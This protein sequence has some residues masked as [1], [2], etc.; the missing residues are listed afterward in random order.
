MESI[1]RYNSNKKRVKKVRLQ[2]FDKVVF[3]SLTSVNIKAASLSFS[4]KVDALFNTCEISFK[5]DNSGSGKLISGGLLAEGVKS[6]L[7]GS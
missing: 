2:N 4:C 7:S 3:S 1:Y 5:F 6:S